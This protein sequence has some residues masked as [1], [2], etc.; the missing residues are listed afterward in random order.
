MKRKLVFLIS[1]S[2]I[3]LALP[4]CSTGEQDQVRQAAIRYSQDIQQGQYDKACQ[5]AAD[6]A[7]CK[8]QMKLMDLLFA[9]KE[10][11][12]KL[13]EQM[14]KTIDEIEQAQVVIRGNQATIKTKAQ[15]IRLINKDNQWLIMDNPKASSSAR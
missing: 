3:V 5:Y 15:A 9:G 6:S 8:R 14:G 7:K 13:A 11:K 4:G 12:Q 10:V 2:V 1:A